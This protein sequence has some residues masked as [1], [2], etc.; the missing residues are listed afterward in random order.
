[1]ISWKY[2]KD[3]EERKNF[4]NKIHKSTKLYLTKLKQKCSVPWD[5]V[6]KDNS[7]LLRKDHCNVYNY[8]KISIYAIKN[9]YKSI[10]LKHNIKYR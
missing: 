5:A 8:R 1:M 4:F 9:S 6:N 10:K 3:K 2:I 7:E